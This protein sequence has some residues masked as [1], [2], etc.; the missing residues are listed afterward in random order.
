MKAQEPLS[1][2]SKWDPQWTVTKVRGKVVTLLHQQTNKTKVLNVN[3][4]RIVDP[5]IA[6]DCV[7]P[8][9]IRN[10]R[11][12][13]RTTG[14]GANTTR[15]MVHVPNT[16]TDPAPP[17]KRRRTH[18]DVSDVDAANRDPVDDLQPAAP[19]S[20]VVSTSQTSIPRQK[21]ST[22][23]ATHQPVVVN[24]LHGRKAIAKTNDTKR[25]HRQATRRPGA[26][27]THG[28]PKR[29]R[30]FLPR[31]TKRTVPV[32]LDRPSTQQ[33]KKQCID[34]IQLVSTLQLW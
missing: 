16:T 32:A 8:R 5:N 3:K 20:P 28:S 4:V 27:A 10:S 12:S 31:G 11:V 33:Q 15:V 14:L 23:T 24:K 7:N 17:T 25:L 13:T 29:A 1:L 18:S 26:L 22:P 21:R 30:P 6:W 9:P 2:T 19:D 34:L